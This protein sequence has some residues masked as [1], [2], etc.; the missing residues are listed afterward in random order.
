MSGM[1]M[2]VSE[3]NSLRLRE[4]FGWGHVKLATTWHVLTG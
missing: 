4:G 1:S 2:R 3:A